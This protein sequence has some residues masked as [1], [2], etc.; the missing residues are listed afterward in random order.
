MIHTPKKFVFPTSK[1]R[2]LSLWN[3]CFRFHFVMQSA[4]R[5]LDA[6]AAR[7]TG[8]EN[9][10][11]QASK[12]LHALN[13]LV[14]S[15][16]GAQVVSTRAALPARPDRVERERTKRLTCHFLADAQHR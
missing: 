14:S 5:A 2:V 10:K 7:T 4:Q 1:H 11:A 13:S 8:D 15:S 12:A 3:S 16:V 6:L 9:S